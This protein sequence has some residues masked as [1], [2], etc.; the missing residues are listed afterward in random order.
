MKV[1]VL[2]FEPSEADC[3]ILDSTWKKAH[4]EPALPV[5]H[6]TTLTLNCQE[7]YTN[8]RGNTA[9]CLY[10]QVILNDGPPDCRIIGRSKIR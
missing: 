3:T 1:F 2:F 4:T 9:S 10:G 7:G 6:G 5:V 8:L